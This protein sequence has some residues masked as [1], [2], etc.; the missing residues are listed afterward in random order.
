MKNRIGKKR[1]KTNHGTIL[2]IQV[3]REWL[4]WFKN[5]SKK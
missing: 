3:F 2:K 1:K 5:Q 4:E